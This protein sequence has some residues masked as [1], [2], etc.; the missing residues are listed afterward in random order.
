MD[1]DDIVKIRFS[2]SQDEYEHPIH[3]HGHKFW[4]TAMDGGD[5][6]NVLSKEKAHTSST[7]NPTIIG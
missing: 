6:P 3:L 7:G 4:Q 5:I 1:V 2:N